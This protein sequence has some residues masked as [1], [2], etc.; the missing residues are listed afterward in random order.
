MDLVGLNSLRDPVKAMQFV[1]MRR[2]L[3]DEIPAARR[4]TR[5]IGIR[6]R[7]VITGR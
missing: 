1:K 3:R 6:V 4:I 5:D 7:Y 2:F